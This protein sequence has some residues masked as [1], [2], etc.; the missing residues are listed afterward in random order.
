MTLQGKAEKSIHSF[1]VCD[2]GL[3]ARPPNA[4]QY[5]Q[6]PFSSRNFLWNLN[7]LHM[8]LELS[9]HSGPERAHGAIAGND[10]PPLIRGN[11]QQ[12][13]GDRAVHTHPL[14]G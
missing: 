1:E 8:P 7:K 4:D 11:L 14:V 6:P 2:S 3:S 12:R 13:E 9:F 5:R 10:G